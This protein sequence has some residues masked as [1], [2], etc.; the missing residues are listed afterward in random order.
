[1]YLAQYVQASTTVIKH[2]VECYR[3]VEYFSPVIVVNMWLVQV[4]VA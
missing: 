3:V 2:I 4:F 1:M